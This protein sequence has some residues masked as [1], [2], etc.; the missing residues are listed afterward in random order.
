MKAWPGRRLGKATLTSHMHPREPTSCFSFFSGGP[1]SS[2]GCSLKRSKAMKVRLGYVVNLEYAWISNWKE[3][4]RD[5]QDLANKGTIY[6]EGRAG[7]SSDK[8]T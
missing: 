7:Q 8:L 1:A 4:G 6:G 2:S 3:S 5:E